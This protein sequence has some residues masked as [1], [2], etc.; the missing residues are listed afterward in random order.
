MADDKNNTNS[1]TNNDGEGSPSLAEQVPAM[2]DE[3][4]RTL[5]LADRN[6]S[7]VEQI[8]G[9][10]LGQVFADPGPSQLS[11]EQIPFMNPAQLRAMAQRPQPF[12]ANQ[13]NS[14]IPDN[15]EHLKKDALAGVPGNVMVNLTS[16]TL[17][18]IFEK[19]LDLTETQ[20]HA[21]DVSKQL[22]GVKVPN[23]VQDRFT[24]KQ[25]GEHETLN[26]QHSQTRPRGKT[27]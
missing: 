25:K 9:I 12:T 26:Q 21:I 27:I 18:R 16:G 5:S 6:A 23:Y 20:I 19:E 15:F 11:V 17:R 24:E 22:K 3:L 10:H 4:I 7:S 2:P 14:M 8:P 13:L 1:T